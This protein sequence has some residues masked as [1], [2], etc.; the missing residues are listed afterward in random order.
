MSE[1]RLGIE[2]DKLKALNNDYDFELRRVKEK[3]QAAKERERILRKRLS[4]YISE[5]FYCN[6][7]GSPDFREHGEPLCDMCQETK[8]TLEKVRKG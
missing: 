5:N 6:A 8:I 3:L 2:N 4:F 1:Y 7:C